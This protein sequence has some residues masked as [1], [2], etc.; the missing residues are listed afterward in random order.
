MP[1]ILTDKPIENG[2]PGKSKR[3]WENNIKV[4]PKEIGVVM[5]NWILLSRIGMMGQPI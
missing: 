2:P 3:R 4:D 1:G 5:G